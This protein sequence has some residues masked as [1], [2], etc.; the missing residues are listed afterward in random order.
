VSGAACRLGKRTGEVVADA[1]C[2]VGAELFEDRLGYG[3]TK[4]GE[5][6]AGELGNAAPNMSAGVGGELR[7]QA[8]RLAFGNGPTVDGGGAHGGQPMGGQPVQVHWGESG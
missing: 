2:P 4:V 8:R 1:P 5:D 3:R 7:R 6:R